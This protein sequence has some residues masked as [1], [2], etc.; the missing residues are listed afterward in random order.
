[1]NDVM[2]PEITYRLTTE[3][4]FPII[5][6]MYVKLNDFFYEMGYQL[7]QPED[8]SQAYLNSFQRTLGR[9]TNSWVAEIESEIVGY[10][11]C[12]IKRVP[13]Y[14]GGVL[15][16][17]LSDMW[18]VPSAR[19]LGV[20]EKLVRIAIGWLRELEVHSIEIQVLTKNEASWKI[21]DKMGF[22]EEYRAARLMWEDY[23]EEESK[24]S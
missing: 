14:M 3:A 23:I 9:Y 5:C 19:R 7:P 24:D 4:D 18:I 11:L 1:M 15:V 8:V 16:G 6:D 20:G 13:E 2:T 21:F 22:K 17:E 12:R 10:I